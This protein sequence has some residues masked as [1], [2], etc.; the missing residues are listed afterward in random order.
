MDEIPID[1]FENPIHFPKVAML[2]HSV[3]FVDHEEFERGT[4]GG[5]RRVQRL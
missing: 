5:E 3:G 2:D 1:E 4:G